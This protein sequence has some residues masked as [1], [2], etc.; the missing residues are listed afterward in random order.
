[1]AERVDTFERWR[2]FTLPDGT[3]YYHLASKDAVTDV[4]LSDKESLTRVNSYVEMRFKTAA[5]KPWGW[6]LWVISLLAHGDKREATA[7]FVNNQLHIVL[8]SGYPPIDMETAMSQ[9][10]E[11]EST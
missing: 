11:S 1:M 5:W 3:S 8:K 6:E 9:W 10:S 7:C 2:E 4:D